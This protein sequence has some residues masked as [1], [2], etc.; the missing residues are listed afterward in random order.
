MV[1]NALRPTEVGARAEAVEILR[2]RH[3]R[4]GGW[5]YGSNS[6]KGVDLR[7]Y[8]QTTAVALMALQGGPFELV[9]PGLRFL[10]LRW[11]D[12]PGGLTLAQTALAF[13]LHGER[14]GDAVR[15]A[16]ETAFHRTAFMGNVLALG[17]ATLAT[18]PVSLWG[19]LRRSG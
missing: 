6:A 13:D 16:L 11:R 1:M 7:G 18:S 5:N 9:E 3:C 10:K 2:Q 12:E 17:W 4:D 8:A 15:D 19:R 14:E